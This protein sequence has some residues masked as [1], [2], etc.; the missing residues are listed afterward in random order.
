MIFVH[1]ISI[2]YYNEIHPIS[3]IGPIIVLIDI[4]F[5]LLRFDYCYAIFCFPILQTTK[6]NN[7][8]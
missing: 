2:C 4:Y 5:K 3:H 6:S 1:F 8:E 7:D